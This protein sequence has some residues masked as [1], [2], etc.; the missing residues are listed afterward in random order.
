MDLKHMDKGQSKTHSAAL[1]K[2]KITQA[3][4]MAEKRIEVIDVI[5]D[6]IAH[7]YDFK[8]SGSHCFGV[9]RGKYFFTSEIVMMFNNLE[10]KI[11][12]LENEYDKVKIL[13]EE[14]V[15]IKIDLFKEV[16]KLS[17]IELN[18]TYNRNPDDNFTWGGLS[19]EEAYIGYWNTD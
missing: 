8:V 18:K 9:E 4:E 17:A 13:I 15:S 3:Q 10:E 7:G 12:K 1:T 11:G 5:L 6:R 19:G 2:D 14:I 16:Q